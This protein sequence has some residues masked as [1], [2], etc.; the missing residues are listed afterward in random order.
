MGTAVKAGTSHVFF[1]IA[2]IASFFVPQ[3]LVV[4][5]LSRRLPVEGGLYEWAR[6]AFND[7]DRIYGGVES[8]ALL[9]LYV[10]L[11]GL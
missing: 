4:I 11:G 8:L 1:W 10:G 2:A 9:I 3:A 6:I 5:H 7:Q